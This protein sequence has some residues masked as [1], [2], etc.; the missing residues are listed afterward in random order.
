MLLA[1][2]EAALLTVAGSAF[3]S[4]ALAGGRRPSALP[5]PAERGARAAGRSAAGAGDKEFNLWV[6]N[7]KVIEAIQQ[8]GNR[9]T[10]ADVLEKG[11]AAAG[12][13]RE[14]LQLAKSTGASLIVND[15]GELLYDFPSDIGGALRNGNAAARLQQVVQ[16]VMPW[17]SWGGR[18]AFGASLL[19]TVAVLY[20]AVL[21]LISSRTSDREDQNGNR[22]SFVSMN[23]FDVWF[24]ADI[25]SWFLPRPYGYSYYYDGYYERKMS[26]F[27]AI[28]SFVFGDGD[29]N[30]QLREEKRWQLIG[31][32]ISK[33]GGAI[34]AEQVAPFLDP[35]PKPID[36]P[37]E[38]R[39]YLDKAMLPVL[40]R[41]KGRAE[42]TSEGDI[43]YVFPELQESRAANEL[44]ISDV[45]TAELKRR[46]ESMGRPT[47]AVERPE[48]ASAYLQAVED[49]E[50]S[51][52]YLS[53]RTQDQLNERERKF[54]EAEEG[55]LLMAGGYGAFALL[56]TLFLGSQIQT[57]KA[58]I[59]AKVFPIVGL[60]VKGF[61]LLLGYSLLFLGIPLVRFLRLGAQNAEIQQR[62]SWR[63]ERSQALDR[64]DSSL[65]AR[66][67]GAGGWAQKLKAFGKS[68]FDSSQPASKREEQVVADELR[69]FD[70]KLGSR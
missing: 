9:V 27:E 29:P 17:L 25:L 2:A 68:I 13:E 52:S 58:L 59:L 54:S 66:I 14:L 35:P 70:Q 45:P 62:N 46:L 24:G 8:A 26:F 37:Y 44:A 63:E 48:I 55:Q 12:L 64:P 33:S 10:K 60:V 20:S 28:F 31:E 11:V 41:F 3:G 38:Q 61:P 4:A 47:S 21:I 19:V 18:V 56:A 30:V 36:D 22:T 34:V 1:L 53:T 42:V 49:T 15:K 40:L 43:A 39:K 51:R 67:A 7:Q 65:R 32:R 50:R 5:S 23:S 16:T 57:G 6:P 69:A